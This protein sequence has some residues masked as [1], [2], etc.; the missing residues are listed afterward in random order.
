MPGVPVGVTQ[1]C[2]RAAVASVTVRRDV[3]AAAAQRSLPIDHLPLRL[4][5]FDDDVL[6]WHNWFWHCRL[7]IF[8]RQR[9][10]LLGLNVTIF[11]GYRCS[12]VGRSNVAV[13]LVS[14]VG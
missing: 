1:S 13:A 7:D 3:G 4:H 12:D 5:F 11:Y 8:K 10:A 14:D 6:I 9:T 2:Q